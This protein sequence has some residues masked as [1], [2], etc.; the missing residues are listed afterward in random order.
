MLCPKCGNSIPEGAGFCPVCQADLSAPAQEPLFQVAEVSPAPENIP[1]PEAAPE[2][3]PIPE[4]AEAAPDF[5]VSSV[6]SQPQ[7]K[8]KKKLS[9]GKIALIISAVVVLV[10]TILVICNWQSIKGWYYRNWGDGEDYLEYVGTNTASAVA[11][12]VSGLYSNVLNLLTTDELASD[13]T[14]TLELSS[15]VKS[16]LPVPGSIYNTIN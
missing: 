8:A 6:D 11:S 16:M 10:S 15:S 13:N 3:A 2:A 7:P 1:T 9:G 5:Q 4:T 12:D 14:I